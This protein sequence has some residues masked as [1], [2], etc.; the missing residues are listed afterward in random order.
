MGLFKVKRTRGG[1]IVY[2]FGDVPIVEIGE[3]MGRG[4]RLGK[5]YV[6]PASLSIKGVKVKYFKK[7]SNAKKY[8]KSQY[9]KVLKKALSRR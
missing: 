5:Y 6:A 3:T 9:K 1:D 7:L 4:K 8:A 2:C